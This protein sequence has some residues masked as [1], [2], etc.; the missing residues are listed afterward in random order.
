MA[1]ERSDG[2]PVAAPTALLLV[3]AGLIV[4]ALVY[5]RRFVTL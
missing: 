2:T 4:M 1:N 5:R 3:G